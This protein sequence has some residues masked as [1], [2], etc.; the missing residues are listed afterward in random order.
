MSEWFPTPIPDRIST[1]VLDGTTVIPYCQLQR[2]GSGRRI[3]Y[4]YSGKQRSWDA[5][6]IGWALQCAV[7][8]VDLDR[9]DTH[10]L[11]DET[12]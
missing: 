10:D 12:I 4:L 11:S 6:E 5:D 9:D 7:D 2:L 8:C 3:L 1:P